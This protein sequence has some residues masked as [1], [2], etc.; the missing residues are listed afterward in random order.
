MCIYL[1][2]LGCCG[3]LFSCLC[4]AELTRQRQKF[5]PVFPADFRGVRSLCCRLTNPVIT[6]AQTRRVCAPSLSESWSLSDTTTLLSTGAQWWIVKTAP[7]L[8]NAITSWWF[9]CD[10]RQ[11]QVSNLARLIDRTLTDKKMGASVCCNFFCQ[12]WFNPGACAVRCSLLW[13][14]ILIFN[15]VS[16]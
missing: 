5:P 11:D 6:P 9:E 16:L 15:E 3:W 4:L 7:G 10:S 12:I 1:G 8:I 13:D 14:I 2:F